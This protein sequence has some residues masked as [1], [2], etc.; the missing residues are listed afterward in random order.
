VTTTGGNSLPES[1]P[2][3]SNCGAPRAPGAKFCPSCGQPFAASSAN[4]P[5]QLSKASQ[6]NPGLAVF[7]PR[8]RT[9]L[10]LGGV[11]FV[12]LVAAAA[13]VGLGGSGA[14]APHHAITGTLQLNDTSDASG[15]AHGITA[16][17]ANQC[18]GSGGF[19][20]IVP[21]T[22]VTVKDG[23]GKLLGTGTLSAGS[24]DIN[25]CS[26]TFTVAGVPEVAFYAI[27]VSH[28]GA[29]DFSLAQMQTNGWIVG[30]SLGN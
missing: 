29:L 27:E 3:C 16:G 20:D 22:Q 9:W 30:M 12:A 7:V 5:T 26:L 4:D 23:D 18:N 21:G 10:I 13:V 19:S 15:G 24:G 25:H 11:I 6:P 2:F 14:V 17:V 8:R 28:R 1:G